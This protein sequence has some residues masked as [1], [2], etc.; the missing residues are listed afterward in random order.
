MSRIPALKNE[1]FPPQVAPML[2]AV[3]KKLGMI[4]NMFRTLANAPAALAVYLHASEAIAKG[5]LTAAQREI[6][7]LAVGQANECAY[8]LAAHTMIGKGA[9]LSEDA[10]QAARSGSGSAIASLAQKITLT[11]G[12]LSDDDIATARAKGVT[13]EQLLELVALVAINTLTNYVNHI[14]AT[15][16]DFPAVSVK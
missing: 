11:R 7:A 16:V 5:A 8:C 1:Q 13:D 2:D 4:P 3:N 10:V 6:V 15:E 9:G 12:N 14:A